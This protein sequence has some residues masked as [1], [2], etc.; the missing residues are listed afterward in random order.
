MI[1]SA[2]ATGLSFTALTVRLAVSMAFEYAVLPPFVTVLTVVP[3][4]PL[5]W[6]Q[7]RK[8]MASLTVPLKFESPWK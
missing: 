6:S 3:A 2:T 8:V 7:A 5:V 1:R 4:V